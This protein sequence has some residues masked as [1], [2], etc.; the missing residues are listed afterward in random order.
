MVQWRIL[1]LPAASSPS[2]NRRISLDPKI[3]FIIFEMEPP[4]SAVVY[5]SPVDA[6]CRCGVASCAA[7]SAVSC[8]C[9]VIRVHTLDS[10]LDLGPDA[11]VWELV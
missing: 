2:I 7:V 9:A 3:L 10:P 5:G 1:V 8:R 11:M 4:I 6:M